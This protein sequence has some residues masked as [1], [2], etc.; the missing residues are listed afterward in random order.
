MLI[1]F[2]SLLDIC[3]SGKCR[4]DLCHLS[5]CMLFYST[6]DIGGVC[7]QVLYQSYRTASQSGQYLLA[8]FLGLVL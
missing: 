6:V 7:T 3:C 5:L 4:S 1:G 8:I 2:V